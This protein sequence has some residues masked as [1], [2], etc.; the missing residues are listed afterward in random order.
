MLISKKQSKTM[1]LRH[2]GTTSIPT[3]RRRQHLS[4]VFEMRTFLLDIPKHLIHRSNELDVKSFLFDRSWVIFNE[5]G[6]K[7]VFVF[8][9]DGRLIISTNGLVE[10][11]SWQY[12]SANNSIVISTSTAGKMFHPAF[13]DNNILVLELDGAKEKLFMVDESV[14]EK[15]P[16]RSFSDVEHYFYHLPDESESLPA[17]DLQPYNE[18]ECELHSSN[19][20][21]SNDNRNNSQ[22]VEYAGH[23]FSLDETK[24]FYIGED[25]TYAFDSVVFVENGF[26]VKKRYIHIFFYN[27]SFDDYIIYNDKPDIYIFSFGSI[28]EGILVGSTAQQY[29]FY[30]KSMERWEKC[31]LVEYYPVSGHFV[32]QLY[33]TKRIVRCSTDKAIKMVEDPHYWDYR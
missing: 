6:D 2:I 7:Q 12:I 29:V 10:Y 33:S 19:Y 15:I 1:Y 11:K 8:L 3:W 20:Y 27:N 21:S 31:R 22:V 32:V 13:Y 23:S 16:M 26:I 4:T 18:K 24:Q 14:F 28:L 5:D 25:G 30:E 17:P 9:N